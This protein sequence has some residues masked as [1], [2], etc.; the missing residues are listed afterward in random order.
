MFED[1]VDAYNAQ[2]AVDENL[3]P[4]AREINRLHHEDEVR[5]RAFGRSLLRHIWRESSSG[6]SRSNRERIRESIRLYSTVAWREY[7]NPDVYRDA[8]LSDPYGVM[9]AAWA[10]DVAVRRRQ[11]I[12]APAIKFLLSLGAIRE[13]DWR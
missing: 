9:R 11:E 7:F 3:V 1:I 4:V 2:M 10:S 13:E 12:C 8:G 5:H 6:W